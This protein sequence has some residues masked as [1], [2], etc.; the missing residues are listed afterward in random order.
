MYPRKG[1][2]QLSKMSTMWQPSRKDVE[3]RKK[4][5]DCLIE[6]QKSMESG[7]THTKEMVES[8]SFEVGRIQFFSFLE[9]KF[10]DAD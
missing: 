5:F 10:W 7:K 1:Q 4:F 2:K 9:W 3:E 6:F 8:F